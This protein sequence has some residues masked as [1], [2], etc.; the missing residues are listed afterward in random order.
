MKAY[1]VSDKTS[2]E[3]G[4][5][6]VFAETRGK[7]KVLAQRTSICEDAQFTDIECYREPSL[8][9]H[10]K[11]GKTE[12]DWNDK[13]DRIAL[14]KIGWSCIEKCE[15]ENCPATKWC[16]RYQDEEE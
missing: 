13:A 7:A 1:V 15:S 12:M 9:K 10:Y 6:V 11:K 14:C 4:N 2:G 3:G 8:D 5:T 16:Y